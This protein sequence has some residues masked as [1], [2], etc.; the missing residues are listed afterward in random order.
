MHDMNGH[1]DVVDWCGVS[2][3]CAWDVRTKEGRK[4]RKGR[5]FMM[6]QEHL[7]ECSVYDP[8]KQYFHIQ[9]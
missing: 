9:I 8:A 3:G 7:Q 5:R 6:P 2:M 4:E 1:I